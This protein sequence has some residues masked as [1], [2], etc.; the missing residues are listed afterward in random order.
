MWQFTLGLM[1]GGLAGL[2]LAWWEAI[3]HHR[4]LDELQEAAGRF[5]SKMRNINAPPPSKHS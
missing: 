4:T 3:Q 5:Y 1:V 2:A